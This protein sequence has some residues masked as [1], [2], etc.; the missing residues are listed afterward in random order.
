M[1]EKLGFELTRALELGGL[2]G[3]LPTLPIE[4]LRLIGELFVDFV[5]LGLLLLE[6]PLRRP[7]RGGL[8]LE[9][10]VRYTQLLLLRLELLGLPLRLLEEIFELLLVLRRPHGDGQALAQSLEEGLRRGRRLAQEAQLEDRERLSLDARRNDHDLGGLRFAGAGADREEG[11]RQ[12]PQADDFS[13]RG[14][15]THEAFALF[16]GVGP[17]VRPVEPVRRLSHPAGPRLREE[18]SHVS[19]GSLGEYLER[20]GAELFDWPLTLQRG[21]KLRERRANPRLGLR[22][23]ARGHLGP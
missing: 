3:D 15:S 2:G 20:A 21:E 4:L 16:E 19:L 12:V 23:F 10:F 7:E 18:R 17:G 5:E 22:G 14:R 9:L 13:V 8:R 11:R 1:F 6:L